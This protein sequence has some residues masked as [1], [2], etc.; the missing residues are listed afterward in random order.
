MIT[1]RF[2]RHLWKVSL[3]NHLTRSIVRLF[4]LAELARR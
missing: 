2:E 3:I 4:R 1:L